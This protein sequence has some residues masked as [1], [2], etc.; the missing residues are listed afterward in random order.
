MCYGEVVDYGE[1]GRIFVFNFG[2]DRYLFY[3]RFWVEEWF[4]LVLKG[5]FWSLREEFIVCKGWV[6]MGLGRIGRRL[7]LRLGEK[8]RVFWV[9][10][11]VVVVM[12]SSWIWVID[13]REN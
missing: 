7:L 1:V 12:G 2:W 13:G 11:I 9:G 10:V 8:M 6:R 5:F 4:D 3:K